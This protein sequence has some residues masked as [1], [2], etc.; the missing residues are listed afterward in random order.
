MDSTTKQ[1]GGRR[2]SRPKKSKGIPLFTSYFRKKHRREVEKKEEELKV[3]EQRLK[4]VLAPVRFSVEEEERLRELKRAKKWKRIQQEQQNR[5]KQLQNKAMPQIPESRPVTLVPL[6]TRRELNEQPPTIMGGETFAQK[7]MDAV[8]HHTWEQRVAII[9]TLMLLL[10]IS[11]HAD[12]LG[13]KVL[14]PVLFLDNKYVP[15]WVIVLKDCGRFC[16]MSACSLI[17]F[18]LCDI[19]LIYAFESIELGG[20]TGPVVKKFY[21]EKVHLVVATLSGGI[22]ALSICKALLLAWYRMLRD[23][24]DMV[25]TVGKDSCHTVASVFQALWSVP[26]TCLSGLQKVWALV[27]CAGAAMQ[28]A[29]PSKWVSSAYAWITRVITGLCIWVVALLIPFKEGKG[30]FMNSVPDV[31][32]LDG[33]IPLMSAEKDNAT[34]AVALTRT[35]NETLN[36]AS[37]GCSLN[38]TLDAASNSTFNTALRNMS[39]DALEADLE[40]STLQQ[41]PYWRDD[42][43]ETCRYLLTHSAVFLVALLIAFNVLA[44]TYRHKDNSIDQDRADISVALSS[45]RTS[46]TLAKDEHLAT[47]LSMETNGTFAETVSTTRPTSITVTIPVSRESYYG[48]SRSSRGTSRG[49]RKTNR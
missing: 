40:P 8:H 1:S 25:F 38:A 34:L 43:F 18:A 35:L 7:S 9:G 29:S 11:L 20:K 3:Y 5:F 22:V 26:D 44:K 45:I 27:M 19:S 6:V 49:S 33:S 14:P 23:L 30:E 31:S 16:H 24:V 42:A 15:W 41:V 36:T 48:G 37:L 28:S 17:H 2:S 13:Q 10:F 12:A 47:N 39:R 32:A 46:E 21:R 4:D